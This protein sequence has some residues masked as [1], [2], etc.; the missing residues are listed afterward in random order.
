MFFLLGAAGIVA[1]TALGDGMDSAIAGNSGGA[2]ETTDAPSVTTSAQSGEG[3]GF[4]GHRCAGDFITSTVDAGGDALGAIGDGFGATN[5]T[6]AGLAGV[7][8]ASFLGGLGALG[9][10]GGS[11]LGTG[12]G[13]LGDA[14]R[15]GLSPSCLLSAGGDALGGISSGGQTFLGDLFDNGLRTLEG[16]RDVLGGAA[17]DLL[18]PGATL[19]GAG[20]SWLDD[21]VDNGRRALGLEVLTDVEDLPPV[22]DDETRYL[23]LNSAN[24]NSDPYRTADNREESADYIN[25]AGAG[26]IGLQEVHHMRDP[27][28]GLTL[29]SCEEFSEVEQDNGG[30]KTTCTGGAVYPDEPINTAV[31]IFARSVC[32]GDQAC[33]DRI[34]ST[35][36]SSDRFNTDADTHIYE[37]AEGTVV[38]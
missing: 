22:G 4:L 18:G 1:M 26:V 31:D 5:D 17:G 37:T 27:K 13:F 11:L 24:G 14:G 7:G 29:E 10:L 35:P 34:N 8:G 30:T 20:S 12:G 15:C 38:F 21:L 19:L 36:S 23:S 3:C 25:E 6:V 33:I 9:G 16:A 32:D 28:A 2:V